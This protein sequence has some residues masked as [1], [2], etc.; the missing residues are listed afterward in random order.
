MLVEL[1][2]ERTTQIVHGPFASVAATGQSRHL[3]ALDRSLM[4]SKHLNHFESNQNMS[5]DQLERQ[6]GPREDTEA[7]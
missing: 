3:A 6:N 2:N 7:T 4:P 5:N 1:R